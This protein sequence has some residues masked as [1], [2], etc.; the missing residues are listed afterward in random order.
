MSNA[1][2]KHTSIAKRKIGLA[3]AKDRAKIDKLVSNYISTLK[4][5]DFP[6]LTDAALYAG[7]AEKNL[8][9]YEISTP[10][11]SKIRE[12]LDEIRDRQKSF[13]MKNGLFRVTDSRITGLLLEANHGVKKDTP[14]NL[15]QNNI[16]NVSPEVLSEAISLSREKKPK[17]VAQSSDS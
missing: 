14:N 13:L 4:P 12:A 5:Q 10:D 6:S 3:N 11:G 15:T 17:K 1:G 8:I 16:F 2:N 7:I 9:A